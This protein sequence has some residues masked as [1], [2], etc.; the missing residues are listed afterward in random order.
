MFYFTDQIPELET[1][2]L[3]I[4]THLVA[5]LLT[6]ALLI[7]S[8]ILLLKKHPKANLIYACAFGS[9][10]YSVIN[11]S[12]YFLNPFD[13]AMTIMFSFILIS[14]SALFVLYIIATNK[15]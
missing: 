12:G 15:N 11:S 2:P 13:I 8:G 14:T 9:L 6:A 10:L 7:L 3:E 4:A 5:E 1:A